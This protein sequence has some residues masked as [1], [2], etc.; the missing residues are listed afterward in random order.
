MNSGLILLLVFVSILVVIIGI[1]VFLY[2]SRIKDNREIDK[3]WETFVNAVEVSDIDLIQIYG[4]KLIWNKCLKQEQ[5]TYIKS[6]LDR[7]SYP[8]LEHLKLSVFNKLL[9]YNRILP[10]P[11]SS[12][13]IKQSW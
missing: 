5:L 2:L 7:L 3:D 10:S 9:H 8:E 4:Y 12:G 11:G 6:T 1:Q 13:G